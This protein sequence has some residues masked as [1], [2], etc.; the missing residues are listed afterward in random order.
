MIRVFRFV[1]LSVLILSQLRGKN[2]HISLIL[3]ELYSKRMKVCIHTQFRQLKKEVIVIRLPAMRAHVR[4]RV[5]ACVRLSACVR[6]CMRACGRAC[7][8]AGVRARVRACVKNQ[9]LK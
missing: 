9:R 2:I 8:R 6:A 1:F 5:R 3:S 4:V 7:G